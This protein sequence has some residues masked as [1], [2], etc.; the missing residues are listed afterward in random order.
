MSD[1]YHH[2]NLREALIEAGIR[3]INE[4]GEDALSLRK[5]ASACD[6]SHAAPY[7][8]FKDKDELIEAIKESVT[9]QLMGELKDA[10]HSAEDSEN[11]IVGMGKRYV[12]F[13]RS[14]PDYFK[15]LFGRQNITAHLKIESKTDDDYPPF[16][17]LKETYLKYLKE[18]GIKKNRKDQ[19]IELVKIWASAHGLA[20]IACMSGVIPS[21]DWDEMLEGD[22]LLR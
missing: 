12:S 21:F 18:S 4:R 16:V 2:G 20:A 22:K 19:E 13:F 7:A 10:V 6:V 11:A 14:N 15:F 17:L 3:I 8:H 9:E 1:T 5:V